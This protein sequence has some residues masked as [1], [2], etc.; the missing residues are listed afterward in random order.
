MTGLVAADCSPEA[1]AEAILSLVRDPGLAERLGKAGR[2]AAEGRFSME[3][4]MKETTAAFCE[5]ARQEPRPR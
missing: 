5:T 3:N 1:L 4:W 2:K